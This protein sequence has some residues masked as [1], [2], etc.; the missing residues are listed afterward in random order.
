MSVRTLDPDYWPTIVL[1]LKRPPNS[2]ATAIINVFDA[3]GNN[4]GNVHTSTAM[5]LTELMDAKG[6]GIR[7]YSWLPLRKK[8]GMEK[9]GE[10]VSDIYDFK[11]TVYGLRKNARGVGQYLSQKNVWF[12]A[13]A[14]VAAGFEVCNPH[15]DKPINLPRSTLPPSGP[16]SGFVSRTHE[17]IRSDVIGMFD[18]LE[19]SAEL[20]ETE[21]PDSVITP[22]LKHQKQGL[23]FMTEKEKL[24]AFGSNEE[25]RRSL[26]KMNIRGGGQKVYYNVITGKEEKLKPPEVRGGILADMM[27]LG[28]T[29]SVLCLVVSSLE[30]AEAWARKKPAQSPERLPL[31]VQNVKTTL[32]V[33][34]LSTIANWEEQIKAHIKD[35]TL[36]YYVFHGPNRCRDVE[37][38]SKYDIVLTTYNIVG[39]EFDRGKRGKGKDSS[40]LEQINW[41]RI[42][43]DEAHMIREQNTRA[44]KA[45]CALDANRRWAV[46]GTPVQNR[47]DDL[48]ALIKF[49]RV[50]PFDEKNGFSQ[51]ILSPFKNADPEILPK[52]R[53]LVDSFTLRR[54]KDRIDLPAREDIIERLEFTP[55]EREVYDLCARDSKSKVK[56]V[57]SEKGIG[58]K[59]YVHVLRAILRLRLVC[60][61]GRELLGEEDIK[62]L[63]GLSQSNAI[64]LEDEDV[65]ARHAL[66]QKQAFDM[67]N[68][69]KETDADKCASCD[70][71]IE[72]SDAYALD[73][74]D[75]KDETI[76]YM[77][78]CFH[79]LCKD[80]IKGFQASAQQRATDSKHTMCPLCDSYIRISSF[81]LTSKLIDSD[82]KA[83][84]MAKSNP[85]LGKKLGAYQGPHTKTRRLVHNLL[86]FQAA[87]AIHP[88]E[89]PIKSV[90]FSGWTSHLDLI[91][92]ALT[93]EKMKF[94]RL[95]GK[96]TRAA[97][98]ASLDAFRDDPAVT[99][100]LVSIGAGG[101]G[102]NLTTAS[103]VFVMEPQFNPA[104]EAQAID[105]IHRL[106]QKRE[107][108]CTRFI[109]SDSFEEKMLE[110]QRKKQNL[111]DIS[112]NKGK[113]D[114][115]EATKRKLEEL[116]SLFK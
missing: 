30:D 19:K 115:E 22:L 84:A 100:I 18:S 1:Q 67:F 38:L 87:S 25:G 116:R 77:T 13:P 45:I 98:T 102:L 15:A 53:I 63:E 34:P 75:S 60:A 65:D 40:V 70:R 42:V 17:E 111:A 81:E 61:H 55:E 91:E 95:D 66:G 79:L 80:C 73:S 71:K 4:F 6:V 20:P 78:P 58:G 68:L 10:S 44:C 59:T 76:G 62:L 112:M 110:L 56:I 108:T 89:P 36:S 5:W 12:R 26:W 11:F 74:A 107:V 103:K 3:H 8:N 92:I 47:L 106:G 85:K 69:M 101:L 9:P 31:L 7:L 104:A 88:D 54:L 14:Q 82:E 113:L 2:T 33:A 27:G 83:R 94:V 28:K 37:T 48:G 57:T 32:L 105:R 99:V 86:E 21:A 52:L 23:Y 46:T 96:M 43:L 29:L 97:R 24:Q 90:V 93:T 50:K 16:G 114:K 41:F 51:Y 49:L 64:D 39:S 72:Q 35:K 109:M